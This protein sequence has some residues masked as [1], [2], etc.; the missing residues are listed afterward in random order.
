M[1]VNIL[2]LAHVWDKIWQEVINQS[3]LYRELVSYSSQLTRLAYK[4]HTS[5]GILNDTKLKKTFLYIYS[6]LI[7]GLSLST[8]ATT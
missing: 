6:H 2:N 7:T 8:E 5:L 3:G 1:S 4:L